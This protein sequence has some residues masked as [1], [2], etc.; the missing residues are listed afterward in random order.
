M[1]RCH[2]VGL[3]QSP[4]RGC[5]TRMWYSPYPHGEARFWVSDPNPPQPDTS[6]RT[7]C[8]QAIASAGTAYVTEM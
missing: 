4:V 2:H 5:L 7:K 3:S 8:T 1:L 6:R